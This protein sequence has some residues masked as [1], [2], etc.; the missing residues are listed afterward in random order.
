MDSVTMSINGREY[1]FMIGEGY[2]QVPETETLVMTLRERLQL[3][4][5]KLSC[6]EGCC[7]ACAVLM[8]DKA[9]AS[10]I[11][12]TAE[13]DGKKI[14]T[15]EGLADP[16]TGKLD[17]VQQA[18]MDYSAFQCGF[19]T[20]GIII[21]AKALLLRN[22]K[23]TMEDFKEALAGNLCRCISQYRVLEALEMFTGKEA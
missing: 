13:C 3:T 8:D 12:L 19:C 23:P 9:V 1:T 16:V 21:A 2:G 17:P 5:T 7:G 10:C 14:V 22:P 11:T 15:I 6:G 18:I 4:G 20:P